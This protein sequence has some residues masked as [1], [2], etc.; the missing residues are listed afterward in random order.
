MLQF[1]WQFR[2]MYRRQVM[3]TFLYFALISPARYD[4]F[5][6][7]CAM[8]SLRKTFYTRNSA[9]APYSIISGIAVYS[10][11]IK[12]QK[13]KPSNKARSLRE[14]EDWNLKYVGNYY[15][16]FCLSKVKTHP[17]FWWQFLT[18]RSEFFEVRD[19]SLAT[20]Q[21]TLE[22]LRFQLRLFKESWDNRRCDFRV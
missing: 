10:I 8:P 9:S 18:K 11:T 17:K 22:C 6:T 4:G 20:D 7:T 1:S 19:T 16:M 12:K 21:T 2:S 13:K 15:S 5:S 14:N 3:K